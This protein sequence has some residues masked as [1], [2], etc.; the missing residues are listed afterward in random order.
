MIVNPHTLA[1][2]LETMP[3]TPG[4]RIITTQELTR[5]NL[6]L[7]PDLKVCITA[8]PELEQVMPR[9][10]DESRLSAIRNLKDKFAFRQLLSSIYPDLKFRRIRLR[11]LPDEVLA[12][13]TKYVL[14]PVKGCFGTGVRTFT[15]EINLT[16]LVDEVRGE[17]LRNSAVLS[18]AALSQ[19]DFL[20]ET[21]IEGE[22]YAVD[23]FYDQGFSP[24]RK[25]CCVVQSLSARSG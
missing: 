13:D 15:R 23:M 1:G 6:R 2:A 16:R 14:K 10:E 7:L 9:L 3:P 4:L 11:D 20:I 21:F 19:D 17:L 24:P 8:E 18:E 25:Y 12:S 5:S 22:E